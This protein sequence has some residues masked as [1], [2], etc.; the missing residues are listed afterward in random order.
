MSERKVRTK[1]ED[2]ETF[3]METKEREMCSTNV[4]ACVRVRACARVCARVRVR[5]SVCACVAYILKV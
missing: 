1:I 3:P 4:C 2:A 5:A